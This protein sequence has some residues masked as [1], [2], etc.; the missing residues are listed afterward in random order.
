[1]KKLLAGFFLISCIIPALSQT[2]EC[3]QT[4]NQAGDEFNAGHFY[5]IPA[6]LKPCIE[7]NVFSSEQKVRAYLLLCQAYLIIDDPIAAEDSYLKLLTADPEYVAN[8]EKDAIDVVFLSKKFTSTPIFTP[9]IRIGG[10]TSL[11]RTI[12]DINTQSRPN[13]LRHV[14]KPGFQVGGGVDWNITDNI[15]LCSEVL[16][17]YKA[18]KSIRSGI[19]I[20]DRQTITEKQLWFDVPLYLKYT[21]HQGLIRPFFYAGIA[22]N[23]LMRSRAAME[24]VNESPS[25]PSQT[26]SAGPDADL[27][28]FR[29][30]VNRSLVFGGGVRY[31]IG[32]DFVFADLRYMA[33]L[34]NLSNNSYSPD[35]NSN[36]KVTSNR[37][38]QYE[39][40]DSKFR[41]DNLSIS[42]GYVRPLY[43]PR[44]I[45]KARGAN[46][47][48][49]IIKQKSKN[50]LK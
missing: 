40:V 1:M 35:Q 6:L 21:D 36:G 11:Y 4:L 3:E 15:S 44:K 46:K 37:A 14:L 27:Y 30:K 48:S 8:D 38:S 32:K 34:T 26:V 42:V 2:N 25:I 23:F 9:H 24:F 43:N 49:R 13:S 7:K 10:N 20:D 41:L 22:A 47:V 50:E 18:F 16:F 12:Y 33:G 19:A 29:R 28:Y 31:K 39:S 17:S 5:G 45:K